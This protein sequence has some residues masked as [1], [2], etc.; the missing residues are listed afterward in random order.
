MTSEPPGPLSAS[1]LLSADLHAEIVEPDGGSEALSTA[2][3]ALLEAAFEV[4]V[5]EAGPGTDTDLEVDELFLVLSGEG[6][7]TFQDGSSV[8][9]RA[10]VLVRLREGDRTTWSITRRLRKLYLI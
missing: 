1:R 9:L 10:G 6:T 7:V 8:D 2:S 4:G 3:H 5:W